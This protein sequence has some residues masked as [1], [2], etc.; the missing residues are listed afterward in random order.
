MIPAADTGAPFA[1]AKIYSISIPLLD[2]STKTI[3][4]KAEVSLS[5][6]ELRRIVS[7]ELIGVETNLTGTLTGVEDGEP[8]VLKVI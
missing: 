6:D 2:G 8:V 4:H 7:D 3:E 1:G 5:W